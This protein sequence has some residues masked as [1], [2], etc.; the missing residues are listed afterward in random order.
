MMRA[1]RSGE[2]GAG[3]LKLQKFILM[4]NR[5]LNEDELVKA[6]ALVQEIR[7]KL[8]NLSAGD[9]ELG[10][11]FRRRICMRPSYDERGNPQHCMRVKW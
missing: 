6:D 10:L 2:G 11:A 9:S 4:S 7:G 1:P 8:I 5:K 3:T